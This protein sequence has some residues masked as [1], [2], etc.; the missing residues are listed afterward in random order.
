VHSLT[1]ETA[2]LLPAAAV[3][4]VVLVAN[5]SSEFVPGGVRP[6][7]LLR[8]PG[9]ITATPLVLFGAAAQRIPLTMIG[10]LQYLTPVMQ[11]IIGVFVLEE[12][13]PPERWAG[14][15][16]IWLAL[17]LLSIDAVRSSGVRSPRSQPLRA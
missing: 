6:P 8:T 1:I 17:F 3:V 10:L 7:L 16:V 14:F 13:M 5:G 12:D 2:V 4:L 15:A 9:L 11:F